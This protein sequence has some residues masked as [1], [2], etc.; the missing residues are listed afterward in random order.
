METWISEKS[1]GLNIE[2]KQ[3]ISVSDPKSKAEFIR[4]IISL[5]NMAWSEQKYSYLI[6]GVA[7]SGEVINCSQSMNDDATYQQVI[8]GFVTPSINFALRTKEIQNS[9]VFVFVIR[10]GT[11][12]HKVKK[13]K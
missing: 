6:V 12:F 13:K 3:K 11:S 10:P 9:S 8:E 1:E 2:F 5:A 7:E 4:D